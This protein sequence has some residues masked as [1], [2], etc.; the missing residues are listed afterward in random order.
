MANPEVGE[1]VYE[2]RAKLT[3]FTEHGVSFEKIA[4]GTTPPPAG[5]ARVDAGFEGT[6]AGPRLKG[7]MSGVDYLYMRADGKVEL[8]IHASIT[9]GEG[10]NV[11]FFADGV[12]TPDA[13]PGVFQLRENGR[14]Q[15]GSPAYEWV[16]SLQI[17][18]VGTVNLGTG[19]L[20][21]KGY[22]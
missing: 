14:L 20:N 8:H 15:S 9:T 12:A 19:E 6:I 16:N 10:E 21:I 13:S 7:A 22:A 17:W 4:S 2:V 5:G 18:A 11:A 3:S 1:L